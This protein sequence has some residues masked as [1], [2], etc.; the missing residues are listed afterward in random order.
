MKNINWND[1]QEQQEFKKLVPGGYI[2]KITNAT[3]FPSKE[4]LKLEYDVAVGEFKDFYKNL[5]EAKNFWGG[6]FIR[7]YKDAAHSFFKAFLTAVESSN[8]PYTFNNDERTLIGKYVGL[9]L[10]EEEYQA[11][12][13][14]VKT[15]LYVNQI[16]SIDA[17]KSKDFDVPALK[18]L[19]NN[20]NSASKPT[21]SGDG[22]MNIPDGLDEELPFK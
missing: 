1:V 8:K 14:S 3:D 7:S 17:I 6:N 13:G 11:N 19:S 20:Q 16:R 15:R 9:V 10:G 4:Y 2:C 12:D 18:E 21:V 5:F 22:F